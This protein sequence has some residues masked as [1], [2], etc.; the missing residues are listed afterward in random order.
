MR[1]IFLVRQLLV[2]STAM[3][4]CFVKDTKLTRENDI[5]KSYIG[6]VS[7]SINDVITSHQKAAK[8]LRIFLSIDGEQYE[9][10]RFVELI[11]EMTKCASIM[12]KKTL[13]VST[14]EF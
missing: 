11:D 7:E 4:S 13:E 1:F 9:K 6:E 3:T 12:K 10:H 14:F 5:L 8:L 2:Q